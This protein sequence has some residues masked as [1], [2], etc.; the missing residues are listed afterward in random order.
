MLQAFFGDVGELLLLPVFL[1]A[2]AWASRRG[3]RHGSAS[4]WACFER[5]LI[6]GGVRGASGDSA[7]QDVSAGDKGC[8]H[9]A[10]WRQPAPAGLVLRA[11]SLPAICPGDVPPALLAEP[12]RP[13][14]PFYY[15]AAPAALGLGAAVAKNAALEVMDMAAQSML[16]GLVIPL[17]A[18]LAWACLGKRLLLVPH[19]LGVTLVVLGVIVIG[20]LPLLG[21]K[22]GSGSPVE[23]EEVDT[24]S[25]DWRLGLLLTGLSVVCLALNT[26]THEYLLTFHD[27]NPL[28]VIALDSLWTVAL[29]LGLLLPAAAALG[30][31]DVGAGLYQIAHSPQLGVMVA[32]YSAV[33]IPAQAMIYVIISRS[34]AL[35]MA[36]VAQCQTG[37]L[38][39]ADVVFTGAAFLPLQL[40]AYVLIAAGTLVYTYVLP[41]RAWL[42]L[43]PPIQEVVREEEEGHRAAVLARYVR[44][45]GGSWLVWR[46]ASASPAPRAAT[47]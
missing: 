2:E 42:G 10:T 9:C 27:A 36:L 33:H 4:L 25:G 30:L 17:V 26:T 1:M 12:P 7:Q 11:G 8:G 44:G 46:S 35:T 21:A 24:V 15:W 20:A 19:M 40:A 28:E 38:W 16:D 32:A 41:V 29:S 43:T 39:A 13:R 45:Y 47:C 31:E 34:G 3:A 5:W 37:V 6:G 23:P 18:A 14:V 22:P